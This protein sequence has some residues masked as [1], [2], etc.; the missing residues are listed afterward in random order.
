MSSLE[1]AVTI[2][3]NTDPVLRNLQITQ[4][5]HQFTLD[6]AELV[7][8]DNVCWC[9]YA[10]WASKQAG[11]FIRLEQV[12]EPLLDHLG[13]DRDG[14]PCRRPWYWR[15]IPRWLLHHPRI[16][17]Y[18]RT[19]LTDI[20]A[21]VA[22]GN[23][24]VYAKLAPIFA[25]FLDLLRRHPRPDQARIEAFLK[26]VAQDPTTHA[27]LLDAF[28]YYFQALE[29]SDPKRR[30]E[31]VYAANLLIG[32][33]EQKRLQEAIDGALSAPLKIN[34]FWK[35]GDRLSNR[36]EKGWQQMATRMLMKLATPTGTLALGEDVPPLSEHASYPDL[37][38]EL[39][40]PEV[41]TLAQRFD[42][43]PNTLRGSAAGDWSVLDDR[44]NFVCDLFRSRQQDPSLFTP[45][46]RNEQIEFFTRGDVP[47]GPL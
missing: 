47:E 42:Y 21:C 27:E 12:P 5:Y 30:A 34:V 3:G 43:T 1:W 2:I 35:L 15:L 16:L 33:H 8:R 36:L 37:L 41:S 39:T 20:S 26:G 31:M 7:D 18:G 22:R 4:S 24:L 46:F 11:Q 28:R 9:A 40:L 19:T 17:L 6:F 45:P 29:E 25:N 44:L 32:L 13:L 14:H 23:H 38:V 10:T